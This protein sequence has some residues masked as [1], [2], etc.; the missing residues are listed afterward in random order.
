MI[1]KEYDT[2]KIIYEVCYK[3][4]AIVNTPNELDE[5]DRRKIIQEISYIAGLTGCAI[6]EDEE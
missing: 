4:L 5:L 2:D 1:V 3:L 6:K